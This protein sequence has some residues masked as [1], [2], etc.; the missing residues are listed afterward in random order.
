MLEKLNGIENQIWLRI[1]QSSKI[2]AMADEDLDRANEEKTSD[3]LK[4][5]LNNIQYA[6]TNDFSHWQYKIT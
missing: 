5:K 3:L 4:I 2:Y 1:N 6:K